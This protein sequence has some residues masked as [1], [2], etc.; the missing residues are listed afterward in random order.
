[1]VRARFLAV[2]LIIAT[3]LAGGTILGGAVKADQ[4][5]DQIRA[6]QNQNAEN[7]AQSN[8][9]AAVAAS[10]QDA[11]NQLAVQI[12]ALQKAIVNTQSKI[13]DL[14]HQITVAQAELDHEKQVLGENIKTMYLEGDISTLEILASSRNL[15]DFVSKQEYRNSVAAKVKASVDKINSLKAQLQTQQQQQQALLNDQQKQ[16][17][18][19]QSSQN[20]Q[21]QMLSYTEG[22][23]AAYDAQI[24]NNNSQITSLR[25]QQAAAYASYIRRSGVSSY[26]VGEAGNGGYPSEW[27]FAPQD[28]LV[29]SWGMLNRECVSY[30]AWKVDSTGRYMPYWGAEDANAY[31][32]I[33]L[34]NAYH[35][36]NGTDA[37]PGS[38]VVWQHNDGMGWLGHVAYVELVNGDGS[39]EVSQYNVI[40]GQFSRMHVDASIAQ[41]LHYIYF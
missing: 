8:S 29:D 32:W 37:Q 25:A 20:Q 13:D 17:N 14:N 15:S 3:L 21:A 35:I 4:F 2:T 31:N 27:A 23:K 34:A 5:D 38:V 16:Q 9:L 41:S 10:Y 11:I 26:G 40:H 33:N 22:Q 7:L 24:K 39:I 36:P 12:D 18:Q 30:V 19:L 6:L 1:M 28:T